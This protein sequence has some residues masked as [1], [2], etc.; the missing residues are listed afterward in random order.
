M[1]GISA[2][3]DQKDTRTNP[4]DVVTQPA[5]RQC[6]VAKTFQPFQPNKK[7]IHTEH[8]RYHE[9]SLVIPNFQRSSSTNNFPIT[10]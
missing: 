2:R 3:Q 1:G 10:N 6:R 8:K 4:Q 5:S 9:Q 7:L